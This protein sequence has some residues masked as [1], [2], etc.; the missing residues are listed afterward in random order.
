MPIPLREL[1]VVALLVLAASGLG[2]T[3]WHAELRWEAAMFGQA[4]AA[5]LERLRGMPAERSA[6]TE[7]SMLIG[8]DIQLRMWAESQPRKPGFPGEPVACIRPSL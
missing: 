4:R 5:E 7:K 2:I 1:A 8:W 3:C 6:C